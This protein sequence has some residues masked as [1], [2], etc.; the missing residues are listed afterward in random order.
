M[1]KQ[2]IYKIQFTIERESSNQINFLGSTMKK[3]TYTLNCNI[4]S[5]P[6]QTGTIII[7]AASTENS[8]SMLHRLEKI[9]LSKTDYNTVLKISKENG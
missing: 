9:S 8:T 3:Q 5:K 6:T 2:H 4:H 1:P 7:N